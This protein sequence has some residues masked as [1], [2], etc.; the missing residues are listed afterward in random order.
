MYVEDLYNAILRRGADAGG[1]LYWVNL[2]NSGTYTREQMLP[3]FTNSAEF[4]LRVNDV[5][6][7]GCMS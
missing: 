3:L 2:L 1:F 6:N 4:Q 5:I 7:A